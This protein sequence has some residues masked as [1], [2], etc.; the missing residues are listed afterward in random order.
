VASCFAL[1]H[2]SADEVRNGGLAAD[3][4]LAVLTRTVRSVVTAPDP[5]GR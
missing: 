1:I 2:A 5:A 3:H 4:A